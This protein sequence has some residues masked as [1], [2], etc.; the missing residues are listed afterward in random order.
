MTV[1]AQVVLSDLGEVNSLP[2]QPL[3]GSA[4]ELAEAFH[5]YE[6]AGAAHLI[7]IPPL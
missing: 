1:D 6:Q 7:V 3:S 5:G 2:K 4:E